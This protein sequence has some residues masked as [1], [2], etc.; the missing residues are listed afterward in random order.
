M[1]DSVYELPRTPLLGTS[2]NKPTVEFIADSS[3][4]AFLVGMSS[5]LLQNGSF[6]RRNH[7]VGRL[8]V[9]GFVLALV[10]GLWW[11]GLVAVGSHAVASETNAS[12]AAGRYPPEGV[13]CPVPRAPEKGSAQEA[14][15]VGLR[16]N[17][18]DCTAKVW[19]HTTTSR[20]PGAGLAERAHREES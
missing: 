4:C 8:L 14:G 15:V 20:E 10:L 2:V 1:Q 9:Q 6:Q 7:I 17:G 18:R 16:K 12:L 19:P 3:P 11:Q 5:V 13:E